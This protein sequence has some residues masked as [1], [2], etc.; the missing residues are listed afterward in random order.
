[1][2]KECSQSN[3]NEWCQQIGAFL[4]D[5]LIHD[6]LGD[7]RKYNDHQGARHSAEECG[8]GEEGVAADVG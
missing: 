2:C 6:L 5:D 8:K 1:L 7:C 4:T 3:A